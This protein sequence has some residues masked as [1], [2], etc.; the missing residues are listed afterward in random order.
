MFRRKNQNQQE[1]AGSGTRKS[2]APVGRN[3]EQ[4]LG[5]NSRH[6]TLTKS[7]LKHSTVQESISVTYGANRGDNPRRGI[8]LKDIEIREYERTLGDNPSCSSGPPVAISWEY[9]PEPLKLSIEE[10]EDTRPPRRSNFEMILPRD[11]RQSM[12]RKE[13]EVTQSQIAAAVRANIKI[14]NQRRTTV[15]NLSKS[16]RVE[17]AFENATRKVMKGL[18]LKNTTKELDKL[19]KQAK[20]AEEQKKKLEAS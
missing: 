12:L 10:Y 8:Q 7:V 20:I 14:K 11:V 6:S 4:K 3:K 1:S 18:L 19:E 17:E 15:N 2:T 13:W 5:S 9:Y 16:T